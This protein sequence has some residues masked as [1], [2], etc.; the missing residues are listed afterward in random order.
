MDSVRA[1]DRNAD[2]VKEVLYDAGAP[3]FFP[4]CD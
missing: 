2:E 3:L 4:A 1:I